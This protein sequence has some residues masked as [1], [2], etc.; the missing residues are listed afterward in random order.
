MF[1]KLNATHMLVHFHP[2]N[3]CQ[4]VKT[5]EQIMIPD[6][7]ECTYLRKDIAKITGLNREKIPGVLDSANNA[8]RPDIIIDYP[9]FVN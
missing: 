7:F 5:H 1:T 3:N 6:V 9:P 4:G 2:N 8:S